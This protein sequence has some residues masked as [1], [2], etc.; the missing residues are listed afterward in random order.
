MTM[1]RVH[2]T[3]HLYR[4][5]ISEDGTKP[6]FSHGVIVECMRVRGDVISFHYISRAILRAATGVSDGADT[7]SIK[8]PMEVPA[9]ARPSLLPRKRKATAGLVTGLEDALSL[10]KKDRICAQRLGMERL[11]MLTDEYSSGKEIAVYTSKA[12]LGD[13]FSE[14][15]TEEA[16][17][18]VLTLIED[19]IAPGEAVEVLPAQNESSN[20]SVLE[21]STVS[22]GDSTLPELQDIHHGG[23]L[24]ALAMRTFANALS[25]LSKYESESLR[26]I[27]SNKSR[28]VSESF[29]E[30]LVEDLA[31]ASRPPGIAAGTR[32]ASSHEAALAA[33]CLSILAEY[34]ETAT[35]ILIPP[36]Q[37]RQPVLD[38]LDRAR[39]VG[40]ASNIFLQQ[41]SERAFLSLAKNQDDVS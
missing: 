2:F 28:L 14:S 6:D 17:T 15:T 11:V 41:E 19:R 32:L 27:L 10:L 38:A 16:S 40:M 13:G 22:S 12:V 24:R 33:K 7:R 30:A 23:V 9:V 37:D 29:L 3:I 25:V 39:T 8:S 18:W 4:G 20:I 34:S 31:G 5:A 1:D 36:K 21:E 35:K 26:S